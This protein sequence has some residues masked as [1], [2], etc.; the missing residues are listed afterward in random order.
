MC[1]VAQCI[2]WT[3][4]E[5]QHTLATS[6]WRPAASRGRLCCCSL[7]H[8]AVVMGSGGGGLVAAGLPQAFVLG[9]WGR[10]RSSSHD[11]HIIAHCRTTRSRHEPGGISEHAALTKG[12][13][14]PAHPLAKH[15]LTH[16]LTSHTKRT[17]GSAASPPHPASPAVLAV[18]QRLPAPS[19]T[20]SIS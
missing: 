7:R 11:G 14:L 4:T 5:A 12:F 13:S 3:G 8:R 17:C 1:E 15:T 16:T 19:P 10:H 6:G 9:M 20:Q 2:T 18:S